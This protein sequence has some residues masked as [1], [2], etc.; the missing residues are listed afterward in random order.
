MERP[1]H[2]EAAYQLQR[3][4]YLTKDFNVPGTVITSMQIEWIRNAAQAAST[5]LGAGPAAED[6]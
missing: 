2:D 1:D 4:L 3:I 6:R 5:A